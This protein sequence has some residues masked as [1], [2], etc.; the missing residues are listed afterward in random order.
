MPAP[1]L[2]G[3]GL[4]VKRGAL[5]GIFNVELSFSNWPPKE[6]K[7]KFVLAMAKRPERTRHDWEMVSGPALAAPG[8]R[9]GA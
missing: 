5:G 7:L 4:S 1:G 9:G 8:G 6:Q 2:P 3:Q